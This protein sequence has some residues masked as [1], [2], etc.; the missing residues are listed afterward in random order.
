MKIVRIDTLKLINTVRENREAHKKVYDEAM[1]NYRKDAIA[2]MRENLAAAEAGGEIKDSINLERP[3]NALKDYDRVIKML[4]MS[5][6]DTVEL[7][8]NE[9]AQYV[10][11]EWHWKSTWVAS[12]A[13]Y[14]KSMFGRDRMGFT[15]QSGLAGS[16]TM[17]G[18]P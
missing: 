10:L 7:T 16:A 13:S 12:N 5:A 14:V 18:R 9:F 2:K 17:A 4:E 8:E 3:M 6:E 1:E 11:D 15:S